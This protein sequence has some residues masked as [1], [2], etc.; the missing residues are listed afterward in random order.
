MKIELL[1]NVRFFPKVEN[2][3]YYGNRLS[4]ANASLFKWSSYNCNVFYYFKNV[5]YFNLVVNVN[6]ISSMFKTYILTYGCV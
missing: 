6:M 3:K 4:Y 1:S 2:V 5:F